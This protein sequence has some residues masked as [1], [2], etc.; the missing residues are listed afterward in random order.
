M[1]CAYC[2]TML[3]CVSRFVAGAIVMPLEPGFYHKQKEIKDLFS[4]INGKIMDCF[5]IENREF[6]RWE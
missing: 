5:G 2:G 6:K 3:R 4:F 1:T